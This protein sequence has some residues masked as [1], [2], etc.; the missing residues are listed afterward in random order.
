[1]EKVENKIRLTQGASNKGYFIK[2]KNLS[3]PTVIKVLSLVKMGLFASR[4]LR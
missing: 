3:S 1:M 4:Q 2:T